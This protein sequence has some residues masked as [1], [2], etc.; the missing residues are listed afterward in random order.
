MTN[1]KS[2]VQQWFDHFEIALT[3]EAEQAGLLEHGSLVG[4]TR[5]F[6]VRRVL[7]SILPPIV[8]FGAGKIIDAKGNISRQVDIIISDPKFPI[9]EIESGIGMY[10]LEGVISTIEIKSTLTGK[11]LR[12]ALENIFSIIQLTPG[13]ED[14]APWGLRI[15]KLIS[16]GLTQKEAKRKAAFEF[17]PAS[18]I[19]AFN[20]ILRKKGLANSVNKWFEQKGK[21]TVSD[22][23]CAVL[24]RVIVAGRTVALLHD[25]YFKIDPGEDII[26]DWMKT[27]RSTPHH[28]MSCW[29]TNRRFG[30]LMIHV[31]HTVC[32][33]IGMFHAVSGAT[34]GIDHYL[35]IDDYFRNDMEGKTSY[36]NIW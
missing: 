11:S 24:P 30:W 20:S 2:N 7:R 28:I 14:P 27:H 15:K 34:Y 17:I 22:G 25:E 19:F 13:L 8:H 16:T 6:L 32:S 10:P 9:F 21:P 31:I 29:D 5:E 26:T 12:D 36:Q 35:S 18:Y 1:W 4:S 33:R 23:L 3:H